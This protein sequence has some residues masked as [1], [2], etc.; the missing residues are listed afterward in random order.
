MAYLIHA[1]FQPLSSLT[2]SLGTISGGSGQPAHAP[3][4]SGN[5]LLLGTRHF[6][7]PP[8]TLCLKLPSSHTAVPLGTLDL[9]PLH[10]P[11]A[12]APFCPLVPPDPGG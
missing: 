8:S 9:I 4:Q 11:K 6:Q 2:F 1:D 7:I 5:L 3:H 10:P 12:A